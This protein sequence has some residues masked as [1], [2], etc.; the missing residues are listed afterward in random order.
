MTKYI[1]T[2]EYYNHI[3]DCVEINFLWSQADV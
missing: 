3:E 1:N 2:H